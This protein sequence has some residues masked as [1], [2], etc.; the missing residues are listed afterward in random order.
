VVGESLHSNAGLHQ[1]NFERGR[2]DRRGSVAAECLWT[3]SLSFPD[4]CRK[5]MI[6]EKRPLTND[7]LPNLG[8]NAT[9]QIS[10]KEID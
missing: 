1:V 8:Y 3:V 7:L 4:T 9:R 2:S 5:G 6:A 10:A